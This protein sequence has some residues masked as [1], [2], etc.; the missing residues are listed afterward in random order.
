[1]KQ[2]E[3]EKKQLWQSNLEFLW[4]E[5][6]NKCNLNCI[7]C[8]ADSSPYNELE[9]KLDYK[10]WKNILI[11]AYSL[12]CKNVQFIGGEPTIYPH[13]N[14]L[15]V[16]AKQIGYEFI[17]VYTNGT[18][19]SDEHLRTFLDNDVN[20]AFSIYSADK[21]IHNKITKGKGSF[22]KTVKNIK[23]AKNSGLNIRAS[24]IEMKENLGTA[25]ETE[26]FVKR[27]LGIEKIGIDRSREIGRAKD[28]IK[29][30]YQE[31]CGACW[32]GKL[33]INSDGD[34]FPCVFSRFATI[35]NITEGLNNILNK[36]E[37]AEF[38]TKVKEIDDYREK[39]RE[40]TGVITND[41]RPRD[42]CM[43][44]CKPNCTP[45][46]RPQDIVCGPV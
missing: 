16:D 21:E 23:R 44:Y 15:I 4:I 40:E 5:L 32:Q 33:A 8:Y 39:M 22:T 2:V 43:P 17:E 13:L 42:E 19:L 7:H 41:C 27:E 1:M 35:G 24:I 18:V 10:Y 26:D 3:I 36:D 14:K 29:D 38:R 46:C 20:L 30:E 31:L 28:E 6:T 37:L 12:N 34:V 11:D 9:T 45:N 25:K